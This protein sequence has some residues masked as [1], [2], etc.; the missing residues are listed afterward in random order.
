MDNLIGQTL[1]GYE[2]RQ[3]IGAGS[4]GVVYKAYQ[5][6]VGRDVAVKVIAP[7]YA[8]QPEFIRRFEFEAQLVARLEHIHIVPLYD[9]WR[10]PGGAYLVMRFLR[11]GSLR[12]SLLNGPWEL[13]PAARL[14][15]QVCS[16][17]LTAHRN[18]VVHR[19][20]KPDNVL[21]DEDGNAYLA[22]FG[23]A[24]NL[25]STFEQANEAVAGSPIYFSPEQ[26]RGTGVVAQTDLYA[27]GVMIYELLTG[28]TPL[29]STSSFAEIVNFQLNEALPYVQIA[30]AKDKVVRA[31][32]TMLQRA[33][34]KDPT[35]RYADAGALAQAFRNAINIGKR[36]TT[37]D[38][39]PL[40]MI[41]IEIPGFDA[42]LVTT[43][44]DL[45]EVVNPYKGL[46]A[47]QQTDA[48]DFFGRELLTDQLAVRLVE[49]DEY[50]RFLAVVGPSGSG[51]S[52]VVRAGLLP[53][54]RRGLVPN[55]SR[56][57]VVEMI[58]GPHPFD[59]L[60][61]ALL[62][63]AVNPLA[64]D[65]LA[66]L[67]TSPEGLLRVAEQA[68]PADKT[69]ELLLVIDQ[70]EEV[71]T[72]SEQEAD[73]HQFM[74]MI[75]AAATTPGSRLRIIVTLRA[76]FYDRPLLYPRFGEMM[77]RRTE[78]VLPLRAEELRRAIVS[79]A[80]RVGVLCDE[81]LVSAIIKDVGEQPGTL[82]LL[83][84]ALTE[85]FERREGRRLTLESYEDSGGVLGALARRAEELHAG[86]DATGQVAV[87]QLFL[88]LVTL[89]EG[90][91]DT[92]RRVQRN[93]LKTLGT[94]IQT[95]V[96][97]DNVLDEFSRYRLLTF[98][99]DPVTR[100]QTIEVAHEALI[101]TWVRLREWLNGSRE[102]L[103]TQ[104]RLGQ[105]S[106]EWINS[107]RDRS[108]L[109]S[110]ARLAQ[111][112]GL[113]L[114]SAVTLNQ[115][116]SI[117]LRESLAERTRLEA[118]E[119][120]RVAREIDL[121]RQTAE[122]AQQAAAAAQKAAAA[123]K[124]SARRLR[125]IVWAM[126]LTSV[127]IAVL[128]GVA[129]RSREVAITAQSQAEVARNQAETARQQAEANLIRSD[130]LRYAGLAQNLLQRGSNAEVAALLGVRSLNGLYTDQGDTALREA[131]N[132]DFALMS[133]TG[134]TDA[135]TSTSFSPDGAFVAAASRDGVARLWD[136]K[137]GQLVREFKGHTDVIIGMAF[138]PDGKYLFTGSFD[139]SCRLWD[140]ATGTE[141][142]K[143]TGTQFRVRSVNYSPNGKYVVAGTGDWTA[144]MWEAQTGT[145]MHQ[146]GKDEQFRHKDFILSVD[147]S[148]DS[149]VLATGSGDRTVRL[150]DV[151]TGEPL[152]RGGSD[153]FLDLVGH[154]A[155][156]E[157]VRFSPDGN[158]LVTA[159]D[160]KTVRLWNTTMGTQLRVFNGHT[161]LVYAAQ[162][163]PDGT[164]LL[165][166]SED[167]TARIWH[168][169]TGNEVQRFANHTQNVRS[170]AW[171]PAG[172]QALTGSADNTLRLWT[173][174]TG[175]RPGQFVGH[176]AAVLVATYSPDSSL[177]LT[178]SEDQTVKLWKAATGEL[179]YTFTKHRDTSGNIV[180]IAFSPDGKRAITGGDD[181]QAW[182]IDVATGDGLK[183]LTTWRRAKD[184]TG[185]VAFSPDGARILTSNKDG[186]YIVW[187][188]TTFAEV[189]TFTLGS[190]EQPVGGY[191]AAFSPDGKLIATG[192]DDKIVRLFDASTAQEI[193]RFEGHGGTVFRV[194]FS[195]AGTLLATGSEDTT[196]RLWEVS[197]GA[198]R[199]NLVGHVNQPWVSF[200]A[201]GKLLVT[202]NYHGGA[203][204]W[205]VVSGA[206]VRTIT[207]H[208]GA[209][210]SAEFSADGKL[211]LTGSN[212]GT[213]RTWL[214]SYQAL[215]ESVC[216][217]VLRDF[218]PDER[219]QYEIAD[220]KPTCP[221]FVG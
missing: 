122:S 67:R 157:S 81:D 55:S 108:F 149:S 13:E 106:Q 167:K 159:S 153:Q 211:V 173:V 9:Y 102:D 166:G 113:G 115:D 50:V 212:D 114:E 178:G 220:E 5:P 156:V 121:A 91:E 109:A 120:A 12:E 30:G 25:S 195:P 134:A 177:L 6:L 15:E 49:K 217:S 35:E 92:R 146:F 68:L 200:S 44:T 151:A 132:Y 64:T 40:S 136:R 163:S 59:E 131:A 199:H 45:G 41:T 90:T 130:S 150:W 74:S 129:L 86:L 26:I 27:M 179:V 42:P 85:L 58:P 39:G 204:I 187:D 89:G 174:R 158:Y 1:K 21:L 110:G 185:Q 140:V 172:T 141:I 20:L 7:N 61:A 103:R 98:D 14:I 87:R 8:N 69:C 164:Y 75:I 107:G 93:E 161:D 18:G 78:I 138:S 83:Q 162:F 46:R 190:A 198:L 60:E 139:R 104:R 73:R 137:T 193:R 37:G 214:T 215:V 213:A 54:L 197:N 124:T 194:A 66:Q 95:Q 100:D 22:D 99:R 152:R 128:L 2:I 31:L 77:R 63:V 118:A 154:T 216:S 84:Y 168:V 201:D 36:S 16:A 111:F 171:S 53:A 101:R 192:S 126:A 189:L 23:I 70:F 32:N 72:L 62:R 96:A 142:R 29:P 148:P 221:K 155:F 19:D 147:F 24:K 97:L 51:K 207:G 105:S 11:G 145:L 38:T 79:P 28:K 116:E 57:F 10:D 143:F 176:Q 181:G 169:E 210:R 3:Q 88:R 209:V 175:A 180:S 184:W 47:F 65:Q 165:S 133:F 125:F 205:D 127:L 43:E 117:Y 94:D 48:E 56:W 112:E 188:A 160:D 208:L 196:V 119:K 76:D 186:T 71:F 170:V 182:I 218:T 203:G 219:R 135:I 80:E 17:L 4:F 183:A 82:P 144:W 191:A 34:A 33:T 206:A 123:E 202:G 52:S